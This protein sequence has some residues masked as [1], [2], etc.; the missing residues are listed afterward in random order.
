MINDLLDFS[1]LEKNEIELDV[2]QFNL[3]NA[4]NEVIALYM[5]QA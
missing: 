3:A 1:S 4:I 2:S 5:D